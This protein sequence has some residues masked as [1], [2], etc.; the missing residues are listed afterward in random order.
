MLAVQAVAY[1]TVYSVDAVSHM[2]EAM[3]D[4][5]KERLSVHILCF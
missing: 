1:L 4:N 2:Y 3:C 5:I